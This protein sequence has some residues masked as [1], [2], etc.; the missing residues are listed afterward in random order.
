MIQGTGSGVGKS[1]IVASLCRIFRQNGYRVAPFKAQN[2]ALNSFVTKESGEMGRAQAMQAEAAGINPSVDMNPIL[3]KPTSDTGAQ[4]IMMGRPIGNMTSKQYHA[5]KKHA[6]RVIMDSFRRLEEE[7]DIIVIEGAGSPAEV[8]LRENDVVNMSIAEL[9]NAP[10]ILVGDIDKGG[11]FAWIVGTLELLNEEERKRIKGFIINKFRGD[12]DILKPGL[13]FLEERTEKRVFGVIP[14]FKG[15]KIDEEDSLAEFKGD[16]RGEEINIEILYLPHIS[17]FT[18]FD[19]LEE[20]GVSVRYVG[21]GECLG[22]PDAI[23]IPGTKNTIGDLIYLKESGYA[24]QIMENAGRCPIIGICGGYQMLGREILDPSH[25]ESK[26]DGIEGLGLLDAITTF[27]RGKTTLQVR[28]RSNLWFHEGEIEGY[29]IHM[30]RTELK[31]ESAFIIMEGSGT[32]EDGGMNIDRKTFGTYI[33]G[34]FDNDG[35]RADF[36]NYLRKGK[37]LHP[38][39]SKSSRKDKKEEEYDKLARIVRENVDIEGIY[40]LI[41]IS[42]Y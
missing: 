9:T 41:E 35:L 19:A 38:I 6:I 10:V 27:E 34:L 25:V 30:G 3:L 28:A 24:D 37:G 26:I 21:N 40:E 32:K 1:V 13:K 23:I 42:P 31:E 36:I 29:E 8:N 12:I 11:V 17:N 14:Y 7:N 33:H 5:F 2:M 18:D 22:R 4:V 16:R 39:E 15:I 20:E